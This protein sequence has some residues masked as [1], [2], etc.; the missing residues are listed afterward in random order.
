[1]CEAGELAIGAA[2]TAIARV[3]NALHANA[4]RKS[5]ATNSPT[6]LPSRAGVRIQI[7]SNQLVHAGSGSHLATYLPLP[8]ARGASALFLCGMGLW[9]LRPSFQRRQQPTP[10]AEPEERPS[11]PTSSSTS[12]RVT[13]HHWAPTGATASRAA[14]SRT[15]QSGSGRFSSR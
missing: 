2:A 12:A 14:R 9:M 1:M 13:E 8:I 10:V 4:P 15:D 6:G 3:P 5:R 11:L 7:G